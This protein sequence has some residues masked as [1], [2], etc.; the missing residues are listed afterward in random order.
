MERSDDALMACMG[1][2][3]ALVNRPAGL[4]CV[5]RGLAFEVEARPPKG[6]PHHDMA[7]HGILVSE[8]PLSEDEAWSFELAVLVDGSATELV[9]GKV[10]GASLGQYAREYLQVHGDEPEEFKRHVLEAAGRCMGR[11]RISLGEPE[12]L[13]KLV[14]DALR[15]MAPAQVAA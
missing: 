6:E 10:V 14:V 8:R 9:A 1:R 12:R 7:R 4:G 11:V 2:R 13:V 3:Y 15:A 5:P